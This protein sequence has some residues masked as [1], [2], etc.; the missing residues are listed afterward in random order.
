RGGPD[1]ERHV[2]GVAGAGGV[3]IPADAADSA[4]DEVR[5]AR[6]LPL[7]ENAVTAKNRR[8][9]AALDHLT[10]GKVDLRVDAQAAHDASDRVPGHLDDSARTRA[11]LTGAHHQTSHVSGVTESMVRRRAISGVSTRVPD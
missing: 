10:V 4:G 6:V 5:V 11:R 1:A 3:V 8:R 7:H 9:T 2:L